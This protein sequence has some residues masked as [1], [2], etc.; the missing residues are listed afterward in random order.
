MSLESIQIHLNSKYADVYNN[1]SNSDCTFYLPVIEVP[2]NRHILV[3]VQHAVIPYSFYNIN[4]SN[5]ILY[6]QETNGYT[7]LV[8]AVG[9][10]NANQLAAYLTSKLPNT[11]VSYNPIT[12]KFTFV[13]SLNDFTIV[14]GKST[15]KQIIGLN[16]NDLYNSSYSKSLVLANIVN[17][18]TR[19][20]ICLA[21]NLRTGNINNN[22]KNNGNIICSIPIT[23]PPFSMISYQN[24][25]NI[26][27]NLFNS[28]ISMITIKILD[29]D[30]TLIDLNGQ[31][32]NL[33]IQIDVE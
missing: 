23:T 29:Q 26:R 14:Y 33:T 21:T 18:A 12:S 4:S 15:C 31:Y 5:N 19:N 9:N 27:C 2:P 28:S 24:H 1:N 17:L 10:Y 32:F 11:I 6:Y 22:Q 7:Q 8:I 20:C 16:T 25:N 13:N 30:G 3:S